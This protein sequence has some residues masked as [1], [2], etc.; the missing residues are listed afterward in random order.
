MDESQ[1]ANVFISPD[2]ADFIKREM[3]GIYSL[4][5]IINPDRAAKAAAV[6]DKCEALL[7]KEPICQ[8]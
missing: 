5:W 8:R 3:D 4:C 6:R 7:K 2:E 1:P